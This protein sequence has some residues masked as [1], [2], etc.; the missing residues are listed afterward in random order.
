MCIIQFVEGLHQTKMNEVK[1]VL[2][3]SGA[4]I[5]CPWT[6]ALL[7][8]KL[9]WTQIELHHWLSVFQLMN[10]IPWDFLYSIITRANSYYLSIHPSI[11][12][13]YWFC[14]SGEPQNIIFCFIYFNPNFLSKLFHVLIP[15]RNLS[16]AIKSSVFYFSGALNKTPQALSKFLFGSL[17][18]CP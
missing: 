5:F 8:L 4:S 11:L 17:F 15:I 1:F 9:L 12:L 6:S 7:V 10:S 18:H 2:C 3:P 14:F 16:N 13:V